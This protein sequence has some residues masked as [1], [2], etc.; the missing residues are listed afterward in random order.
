[1]L[2]GLRRFVGG[3]F[4]LLMLLVTMI[5]TALGAV[6][7]FVL[8]L[9]RGVGT[10]AVRGATS[11]TRSAG[12]RVTGG[13]GDAMARRAARAQIDVKIAEDPLRS[14]NRRLSVM[15]VVLGF[16]V[17]AV[18][19]WATDPSRSQTST[20]VAPPV[21]GVD[22]LA[23]AT[24]EGTPIPEDN[25]L[26]LP[27]PIPVA[28]Q[29]P[30]ALR[31]GGT[32]AY[33]V[34]ERGQS[35]L[36]LVGVATRQPIRI[37]NDASDERDPAWSNDGT[38][39]AY[40]SH[41][42]GNWELYVYELATQESTRITFDLSFQGNPK[43]SPDGLFLVYESYQGDNLDI[44]AV[45]VDGSAAATRVTDSPLPDYA[46]AWS[47]DGRRIAFVSLREGNQDIYVFNLDTLETTNITNTPLRDEENPSWSRDDSQI[48]FSAWENG[49]EKVYL[50]NTTTNQN[51]ALNFG[52]TPSWSPDGVSL[53]FAVDS[54]DG[55]ETYLYANPITQQGGIPTEVLSVPFGA[56]D[57][58]WSEQT[59]PP[60]LLNSGGLPLGVAD[61]LF[62]EQSERSASGAPY[63]L[64][65]LL[66]VSAPSPVLSDLVNDSFNALRVRVQAESGVD[67]LST[68][69]D[70]FWD[71]ERLPNPGEERRSWH[72]TG[73]GIAFA[74]TSLL[75]FPPAIEV[76]REQI[77]VNVYWRI[78]LR[79][80]D[81]QQSGQIGEPLRQLPWDFLSATGN[82]VEAYNQGG[83]YRAEVPTGYYVD[84]TRI[85]ADYGWGRLP[86]GDDWRANQAARNFWMMVK[87]DNLSWCDAML[88]IYT[89]GEMVNFC[90]QGS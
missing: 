85:A 64:N 48:A 81:D 65:T 13:V 51:A 16:V 57:P 24:A 61:E 40:A 37:T 23:N 76:I 74:R 70:A 18:L 17:I 87:Q 5:G 62:V 59:I 67:F 6:L 28:T 9:F 71:L 55:T 19:L 53:T 73:R 14:Q 56:V 90:G 27:T 88:Q 89:A 11:G 34:R 22:V 52:R 38:R 58:T 80:D 45:P 44:Y 75:G 21:N 7:R 83:R 26:G 33:T 82:D 20:L 8:R 46:P 43:W 35:D 29:V 79:V 63:R 15:V 10:L 47:S 86:A 60:V 77:G 3:I 68:L 32:L 50:H 31:G 49:N 12:K 69:D 66:D 36:W 54:V 41:R 42:D 4:L 78:F 25:A 72:M 39:L 30:L 2:Y 84:I 1:L